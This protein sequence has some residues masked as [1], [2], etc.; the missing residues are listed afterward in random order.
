M[1]FITTSKKFYDSFTLIGGGGVDSINGSMG[2]KM[3]CVIQG[4]FYRA[5]TEVN[6]SFTA[7]TK[8]IAIT[9]GLEQR[10]FTKSGFLVGSTVDI[11]G[12]ASN[13]GTYTIDF[14]SDQYIEVIEALVDE[15]IDSI[16]IYD[17]TLVTAM[18]FYYN[19]IENSES[20]NY[21]SKTDTG[22]I[23]KYTLSG[24]DANDATPKYMLVGTDSYGWVTDVLTG[25]TST[26]KI[27]GAGISD[28]QQLF[29]ITQVFQQAPIWY[30][31]LQ[32]NF[33]NKTAPDFFIQGR[34]LKYIFNINGRYDA[35]DPNIA[36]SGGQTTPNGMTAW[37]N[38]N[39]VGSRPEYT[40]VSIAYQNNADASTLPGILA[41]A[42]TK[43]TI[44]LN[45]A[46]GKFVAGT[47]KFNISII[48]CP[49]DSSDLVNT[50]TT[51]Q[52]NIR[53]DTKLMAIADS[54]QN[55]INFGTAYQSLKT[56]NIVRNSANQVTITFLVDYAA[57]IKTWLLSKDVTNRN[58][59]LFVETQDIAITTTKSIDRVR[60]LCDYNSND[61]DTRESADLELVDY[62]RGFPYPETTANPTNN[63]NGYEG[64]FFFVKVPFRLETAVVNNIN[65]F[66]L[67][68]TIQIV[69][70][71]AGNA[72]FVLEE[73]IFDTSNVR[74][75]N[76][77]QDVSILNSRNFIG[78]D[79]FFWNQANLIRNAT[80]DSGSKKGFEIQYGF[81]FRYEY[82]REVVQAAMGQSFDVFKNV[83]NVTEN[84]N[85]YSQ[86]NGWALKFKVTWV[87]K[88]Y[89]GLPTSFT[90]S[91]DITIYDKTTAPQQ[92]TNFVQKLEYFDVDG[93]A[94]DDILLDAPTRI[95]ATFTGD[96][97]TMPA[98]M[99]SLWGSLYADDYV[100]GSA[101]NRRYA[102]ALMDSESDIPFS[103]ANLPAN[104]A[105]L[106]YYSNALRFSKFANRI[107][108]DTWL[109]LGDNFKPQN[110]YIVPRLGYAATDFEDVIETEDSGIIVTEDGSEIE[111]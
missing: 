86:G 75:L 89:N 77:V 67:T 24:L 26:V 61:Y 101:F 91:A 54:P 52:Q 90:A 100:L 5:I 96:V 6:L 14:V 73:K 17:S 55:G 48:Q 76:N 29:T 84:W 99:T 51:L 9:S 72:D 56:I 60:V 107:E 30:P 8:R 23:Q 25:P 12:S 97:T 38:Q 49:Q 71:K 1:S 110:P 31:S 62:F 98:G 64:D 47:S 59:A 109:T 42:V 28:Y 95:L 79:N 53:L 83:Q 20:E 3:I 92:G 16:N 63:I 78:P 18:D 85:K 74:K 19:M 44:V 46:S 94:L 41:T 50:A 57:A 45:S 37:L 80:F 10:T 4:Y 32:L 43:V 15:A 70:T 2:D 69:A 11:V 103:T 108:L 39:S 104:Q 40:L 66:L 22:T 88:G 35:N 21:I 65:P 82:W 102:S 81:V 111:Y 106:S 27:E 68:T 34:R 58:Y 13:D 7:A 93:N 33:Q 105:T 36:H 87:V